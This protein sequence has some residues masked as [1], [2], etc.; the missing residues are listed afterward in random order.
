M[1]MGTP[2]GAGAEGARGPGARCLL[3]KCAFQAGLPDRAGPPRLL[4]NREGADGKTGASPRRLCLS[5]SCFLLL[6]HI[7]LL[8]VFDAG[9]LPHQTGNLWRRKISGPESSVSRAKTELSLRV[10]GGF[11]VCRV[12]C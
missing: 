5:H 2:G 12:L 10:M 3:L 7:V 11:P 9:L 8:E 4:G 6:V 1:L